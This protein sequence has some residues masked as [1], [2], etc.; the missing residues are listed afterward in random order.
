MRL[1]SLLL[2][3][4]LFLN[5]QIASASFKDLPQSHPYHDAIMHLNKQGCLSG[6]NDNTV[7]PDQKITRAATIKLLLTCLD[8]PK[9]YSEESFTLPKGAEVVV[10]GNTVILPKEDQITF[11]I[12]FDPEKYGKLS[13]SDLEPGAWYINF[14]KEAVIRRLVTGYTDNTIKPNKS[15]TKGELYTLLYRVVP[16]DLKMASPVPQAKDINEN[17][18]FFDGLQ[19][20]LSQ[21]I[22]NTDKDGNINP[23]RE[24]NR[25]HVAQFLSDYIN[26]HT[27]KTKPVATNI[28]K[29]EPTFQP[30][31]QPATPAAPA[32]QVQQP[33]IT[34]PFDPTS[35]GSTQASSQSSSSNPTEF[36]DASFYADIFEGKI[37]AS[38]EVFSQQKL[39]AAHKTLPFG[40]VLK[41]TNRQNSKS[42][43]VIVTDRGPFIE[44]RVIDLSK[45]AFN[46]IAD[47]NSGVINV[48][49]EVVN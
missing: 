10:N 28:P 48:N 35:L 19:F 42:I 21:K 27:E 4:F 37:T 25:G 47:L 43:N 5:A 14:L 23:L 22:N 39:T 20:A 38:G 1:K 30:V 11:K 17:D 9:I 26:W 44:G 8:L 34:N 32:P 18:W 13:F 31:A 16:D 3:S 49:I 29:P 7:K 46:S 41:V 15:V 12:P 2:L 36:G 40:T 45:L 33:V 24:L 6:Y